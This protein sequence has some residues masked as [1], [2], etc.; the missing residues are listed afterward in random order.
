MGCIFIT[1]AQIGRNSVKSIE[2]TKK[3]AYIRGEGF[4]GR[5]SLLE[6]IEEN[7]NK[8]RDNTMFLDGKTQ[9]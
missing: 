3:I 5:E 6:N 4:F 9:Y 2:H 8:Q 1:I 7:L